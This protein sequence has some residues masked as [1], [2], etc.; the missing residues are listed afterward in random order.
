MAKKNNTAAK[1]NTTTTSAKIAAPPAP[2]AVTTEKLTRE[3]WRAL[4]PEEKAAR[5]LARAATRPSPKGRLTRTTSKLSRRA[6]RLSSIFGG[7][8]G[9]NFAQ[10]AGMLAALSEEIAELPAD[11]KPAGSTSG[12]ASTPRFAVGDI[13]AVH[14]KR[15][16][17]FA[18]LLE[19][20]EL[21]GLRIVK[22]VGKRC[23]AQSES[24]T[25]LTLA[26]N[27]IARP[28]APKAEETT[29]A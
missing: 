20:N 29:E 1:T 5:K 11:W 15:R 18:G 12:A 3:Q 21:D 16:D 14:P 4:S 13:V 2:P 10:I 6:G 19:A 8:I 23:V 17:S 27:T 28:A 26:L 7:D 9:K 25:R 22:I 24:G